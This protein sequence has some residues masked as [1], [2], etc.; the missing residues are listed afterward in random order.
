MRTSEPRRPRSGGRAARLRRAAWRALLVAAATVPVAVAHAFDLDELMRILADVRSAD[1]TFIERRTV[2]QIGRTLESAGRLSYRAP[3]TFTRE[4]L[5][6][7]RDKLAV[8]GNIVTMSQGDRS[9]TMELDAA[10]EAQVMIEAIRG[11]LTGNRSLLERHFEVRLEGP[12][13]SW[14]L[15]LVP[16]DVRLRGQVAQLRVS[17]RQARVREV[18]VRMADGD[19]SE[20]LIEPAISPAP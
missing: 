5:R 14:L 16:R 20:M 19:H 18:D 9:R 2:N 7:H 12:A 17:G 11:T 10:P 8:S 13:E 3:D 15:E 6:P 4:T 1:A